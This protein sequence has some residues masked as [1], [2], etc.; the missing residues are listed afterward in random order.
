M[1]NKYN[2]DMT[3]GDLLKDKVAG[4]WLREN[5]KELVDNPQAKMAMGFSIRQIQQFTETMAPG[6]FTKK[7]LEEVDAALR[8]L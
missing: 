7:Q 2:A 8:K 3:L 4:K 6:Q 5:M 1:P